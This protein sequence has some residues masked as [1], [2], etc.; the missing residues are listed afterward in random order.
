MSVNKMSGE[1]PWY[2]RWHVVKQKFYCSTSW[3][4]FFSLQQTV[5]SL[6][7]AC[8]TTM[9]PAKL[10]IFSL[11]L[12]LSQQCTSRSNDVTKKVDNEEE[13]IIPENPFRRHI[14]Q[15]LVKKKF[16]PPK[17]VLYGFKPVNLLNTFLDDVPGT[18]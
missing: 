4:L 1:C 14:E 12:P 6:S 15:H 16:N 10:F 8:S 5:L 11:L 3:L 13:S 7:V 9:A 2:L 18:N 17:K